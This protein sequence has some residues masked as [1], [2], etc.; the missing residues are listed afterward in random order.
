MSQETHLNCIKVVIVLMKLSLIDI[1]VINRIKYTKNIKEIRFQKNYKI[2]RC[3][4]SEC[5]K[6]IYMSTKKLFVFK[7]CKYWNIIYI[8]ISNISFIWSLIC[9]LRLQEY[10]VLQHQFQ[11]QHLRIGISQ[12]TEDRPCTIRGCNWIHLG[13]MITQLANYKFKTILDHTI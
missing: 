3:W 2:V 8:L 7:L 10:L 12:Q 9:W 1:T 13:I 5:S 11:E 4:V 6:T